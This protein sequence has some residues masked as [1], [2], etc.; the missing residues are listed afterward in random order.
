MTDQSDTQKKQLHKMFVQMLFALAIGQVAISVSDLIGYQSVSNQNFCAIAPA[1]SQLLLSFIVI[2]TSWVGWHN[3]SFCGTQIKDVFS[4]NYLE[5]FI[6][7]ALVIMYFILTRE[8]EIPDSPNDKLIPN[9][10]FE[11]KLVAY[12][13]T[14]YF[15]WDLITCRTKTK[16]KIKQRLWVSFLCMIISWILYSKNIGKSGTV[17]AVLS[18]DLCLIF[19]IL[20]F[21]A[22][23]RHNFSEHNKK[24]WFLILSMLFLVL[25]F[26]IRSTTL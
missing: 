5:L 17:Q 19:L 2:S 10:F 6:D 14:F 4:C 16:E 8:V 9:A 18:A 24:S 20:T 3:S 12:I 13:V 1:Y 11:T 7:L 23:K 25:V 22:M 26:Y 15:I 21:R